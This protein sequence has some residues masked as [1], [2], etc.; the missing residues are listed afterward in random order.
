MAPASEQVRR[1]LDGQ[2]QEVNALEGELA[3]ASDDE[4]IKQASALKIK[5]TDQVQLESLLPEAFALVREASKRTLGLRHFDVQILGGIALHEGQVAEMATGEGKTLVAILPAFLNALT[6]DGVHVVTTNDYLARRDAAWVGRVLRFLGLTVGV[7][8]SDM[9]SAEKREAYR[10]DVTYVTNQQLGFD[11]LRD[12]LAKLPEQL[13]LRQGKPFNCAIVDEADSVLIDEGRT[14]LVVSAQ[15]EVPSEKYGAALEIASNLERE[16]DYTV[17]EKEKTCI[18]T[19]IGE[20][21]VSKSL[22][23]QDLYDPQD[24]WAPYVVNALTSKEL[25]T[26][27]CQYIVRDGK[28]VVVDQFTGRPVEGRSWS[29]G[30]QQAI[31]AK[32]GV[33]IQKEAIVLASISYQ[34]LFRSYSKL[35][36]MTGTA[37]TEEEEF[38]SIYGLKVSPIPSNKPCQRVDEDDEVYTTD[39][40]KWAAV[41]RSVQEAFECKRPVL[42]GTTSIENSMLLSRALHDHGIPHYL[43]N[44]KPENASREAEIIAA[45]GRLGAVTISTNMAGRGTDIVLGGDAKAMAKLH[46]QAALCEAFKSSDEVSLD[47]CLPLPKDLSQ[48]ILQAA[49]A[50]AG[51][52][53]SW[54]PVLAAVCDGIEDSLQ[55]AS[56][57]EAVKKLQEIYLQACQTLNI[58]CE[59]E[60]MKVKEL[61]GLKVIGTERH[62]AKRIDQQL[63]GRAGRQ[64]DPGSSRFCLSLADRVFRVFGGDSIRTLTADMGGADDVPIVSPLVSGAL[65]E[66]QSQV[67][68]F[69]FGIRKDVFKY[70]EVLDEQRK[71]IYQLRRKALLDSDP[72]VLNSLQ[73]FCEES[74]AELVQQLIS[75]KP[76]SD[77]PL[78]RLAFKLSAWFTGTWQVTPEEL[79]A[80]QDAE[81]LTEWIQGKALAAMQEKAMRIDEDAPDLSGS[82][83]RQVFLMQIDNYW[84]RHLKYMNNLRNYSKLR[85]YGQNDPLVEYKLAAYKA[86]QVM[87]GKIRRDTVY[88]LFTFQPRPLNPAELA[89]ASPNTHDHV[90]DADLVHQLRDYLATLPRPL[91]KVS[92]SEVVMLLEKGGIS[93][94]AQLAWLQ[95]CEGLTLLEDAFAQAVYVSIAWNRQQKGDGRLRKE[96]HVAILHKLLA[97]FTHFSAMYYI[98]WIPSR[99][100]RTLGVVN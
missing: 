55:S 13:R 32:E 91:A 34:C 70:D 25:Y 49:Q 65:D 20:E 85:S 11:Y 27:D 75:T 30:L 2:L 96:D 43:L 39:D 40:G 59:E 54:S 98:L 61:G 7:I 82:V 63:R 33:E 21:K 73:N 51:M 88:Y 93:R 62:E 94:D 80:A 84:R 76:K 31:E 68:S 100:P 89:E 4:L 38:E 92:N 29:D 17:L 74:M 56:Y 99:E 83:Y 87:M 81:E 3:I 90:V 78:E 44:A 47:L 72:E 15:A 8:Q 77:W 41:M 95:S 1:R 18:L 23:I 46:L 52:A 50:V 6:G 97:V 66:A 26:R 45:G 58:Y 24:P 35:A 36:G 14:P 22:N 71:V 60:G 9:T 19:E 48:A 53:T 67:Q 5:V 28:V 69:F 57:K 16:I 12:Q 86:F 64:G 10:C 42:V 79:K 37:A